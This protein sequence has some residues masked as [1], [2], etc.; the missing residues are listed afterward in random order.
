[1]E[2]VLG[3]RGSGKT[4]KLMEFAAANNYDFVCENPKAMRVK[5]EGYG[6][7]DIWFVSYAD[8][9][10]DPGAYRNYVIDEL[11]IF[12]SQ[13]FWPQKLQGYSITTEN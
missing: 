11:A 7:K 6:F 10:A 12:V 1:M 13:A 4:Y 9:V 3:T 8:F 2:Q 5:A